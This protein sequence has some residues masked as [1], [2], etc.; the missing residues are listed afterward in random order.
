MKKKIIGIFVSM[1]LIVSAF[2]GVAA[3]IS[4]KTDLTTTKN[5]SQ[6]V[7]VTLITELDNNRVIEVDSNGNIVWEITGL[8]FPFDS[9]RLEN[10]NTLIAD[11]GNN[12]VIEVD[13]TGNI[14]WEI[15]LWNS[16]IDVER[17][18]N[19]NTLIT[20]MNGEFVIEVDSNG[21][22]VWSY[23]I[24]D[25]L[26]AER[27]DNGNTL[28]AAGDNV[29]EVDSTGNIVWEITE[30]NLAWDAERLDN[31][32]SLIT[33]GDGNR[34]I[35]IDSNGNIIW[36]KTGLESPTDA[37]RLEN[38]NTL[39]AD[40]NGHR[41]IEVDSDGYIIWEYQVGLPVDAERVTSCI[42]QPPDTPII[43]GPNHGKPGVEY[44][45]CINLS[46]P[47]NDSLF[48]FWDWG[49]G[50]ST[51]WIG[52]YGSGEEVCASH[53]WNKKGTY[54]ISVTVRDEN[55]ASVKAYMEVT[56]PRNR[57]IDNPLLRF[58]EGHPLLFKILQ[59]LFKG[60][61]V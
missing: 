25:A 42:N 4:E 13:C 53:A 51:G 47:D 32:N 31:G 56:I 41:V 11:S 49:D 20:I 44:T 43:D 50:I 17:L 34:V 16:P 45:Y 57:A 23:F 14:V 39:I 54:T 55:G 40:T 58:F 19:G 52:P 30:L 26:D 59:L 24:V 21:Y 15:S 29:I 60:L 10:G 2:T 61:Q 1:L 7:S 37:E 12:K 3:M 46:D 9:E 6:L 35:E 18:D 28:I 5:C 22:W 27:L 8:D 48:V 33:E 36:E 38:G